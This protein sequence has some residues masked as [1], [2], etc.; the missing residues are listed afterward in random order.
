M[1][2]GRLRFAAQLGVVL[3]GLL[4]VAYP[5]TVGASPGLMCRDQVL[6]PGQSCP[7]ADGSASQSYESRVAAA[8]AAKPVVIGLG[9]LVTAFG[10]YL[11]WSGSRGSR[12]SKTHSP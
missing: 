6:R 3:A 1:R 7:K 10:G 5:Y 2:P 9:L 8:D 11:L 12:V 4:I